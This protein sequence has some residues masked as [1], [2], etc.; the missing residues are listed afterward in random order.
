MGYAQMTVQI[1]DEEQHVVGRKKRKKNVLKTSRFAVDIDTFTVHF[2]VDRMRIR[3]YPTR[4][5]SPL[6]MS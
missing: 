3:P 1:R 2:A 5:N 6:Y 4:N